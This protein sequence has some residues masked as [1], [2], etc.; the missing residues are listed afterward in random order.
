MRVSKYLLSTQKETPAN[1]EVISH[2]LMLRAGM[3]RRNASG[4]YSYLPTGLRVLRKVEAI[5][6]E[7]MNK[8]GAIEILMPMVQPADLWVETGRWEKF[9]PELLRFKDRHNRDFVLG[10]THEEVITDLIRK[11]VSSYKQLPLNLYQI[12]TKFRDE[13][14][15][16][17]G[18][19]RSREFLMKDAYSF[20]LDVDTMNETYEAMYNAYSNILT[21]MGLAFRPVLADTG[22]IG[23]SM[24][25]E[26]HVLAQ[27]GEDLIAY[28][29]GSDY[30]ANIEKAESPVPT[31]P[32]GAATEELRLVDTPNAKT[33]AELVEQFDLDI[34]KT[35][36][37]LIVVGASEATPLVALIVRGDHELNEVKADKLDL[38]ASPVE[39]ASEALIRDAI[40]AGPGSLGPIGLN[41]PIVIDHSVSV[42]NDFAAGANVDDKHYFGINW[43][44]DLPTAQVADI[45][46]VVE[47][48]P[49]PD[50]S[51][52]YAMAR[53]IE[54]GHIFQLGTNYSKSMNAT[55]LD[56]NG[57]SQ[58]L[59]MGC[60]GVGVSRI[61]AAAIEQNFDDRGIIWPE[62]IA[63][64]SVGILPMNMHKSHRVTDIAEQL[65][66]DLNEAGIDVLLDDRKERPGVMFA[67]MELIG[68]PHT[69]V[70]GDRNI[71][72]GVFEYK[73]R[74]T[75]EKQDIPFDQLLD[76]L[77]NAVKG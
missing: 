67:D 64:F 22:S 40:G 74:R 68:I 43:E 69:V 52:T 27:S 19:M 1:A 56:E 18:M 4:L 60:Y 13:V 9:G 55:V 63:P 24:S 21:R 42:M 39:M 47:G 61:V 54:V 23:G 36:K 77:K 29:T 25:H 31:E 28:S 34:T 2:Q 51:G 53:G 32:R 5:V 72:A 38:V 71:D 65:Y 37:T 35:V 26:F 14:R 41:I 73:N 58:V 59:L 50:G 12:Q 16:R 66:K 46:N 30:A 62:A 17:F 3:I 45:R 76:F 70:I 57:K 8:A 44:R 20:H 48:E 6:R 33:I 11:E 7:E 75:G 15:P 49:T 10:P